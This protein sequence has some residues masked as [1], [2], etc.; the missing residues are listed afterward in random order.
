[1]HFFMHH[2]LDLIWDVV[3]YIISVVEVEKCYLSALFRH[4]WMLFKHPLF[5]PLS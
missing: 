5:T 2:F 3:V 4:F 1:M